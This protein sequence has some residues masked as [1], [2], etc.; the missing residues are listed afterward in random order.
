MI[1]NLVAEVR[2][3]VQ[4]VL[5]TLP[6]TVR[7][8]VLAV[9]GGPDSLCL[10]DAALVARERW[11]FVVA[12]LNHGLRG[13]DA[14]ADAA[15]VQ[16]FAEERSV[17]CA[18]ERADVAAL[19]T[20]QRV[21]VEV[22]GRRARYAFFARVAAEHNAQAI[23]LAH[24]A[25]DQAET[26]LLRLLRGTGVSGLAGMRPVAPLPGAP[27]LIAVRPLLRITRAQT[28]RYCA[29]LGLQPRLDLTNT[30]VRY[31][32]NRVR[33]ELLPLMATFNPNIHHALARLADL[34]AEDAEVVR[35]CAV[36]TLSRVAR[37]E[38]GRVTF[39]RSAWRGLLPGLQRATLREAVR[40]LKDQP[41][42]PPFAAIEEARAVL[43]SGAASGAI[44]LTRD[45]RIL[46]ARRSFSLMLLTRELPECPSA[47]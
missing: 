38:P 16:R 41:S 7:G 31:R 12:H 19:A 18:V 21:S 14:D 11:H 17:P 10:A 32:R 25:D 13:A 26:V 3:E 28:E 39:D 47:L 40:L 35:L 42:A 23:A 45:V 6:N 9:S 29:L 37:V 2:L 20:A 33:H 22:A 43:N 46:V 27:H 36:Q 8:I 1:P 30:D 44:A 24:H 5:A 15:F 4:R 34:A